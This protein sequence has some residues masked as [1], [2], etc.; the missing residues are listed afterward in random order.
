M[1]NY[2]ARRRST[3]F[4]SYKDSW[5]VLHKDWIL[6]DYQLGILRWEEISALY[7]RRR[8]GYFGVSDWEMVLKGTDKMI[9]DKLQYLL[10]DVRRIESSYEHLVWRR[11]EKKKEAELAEYCGFDPDGK[12]W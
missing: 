1:A 2:W 10:K 11:E 7:I 9:C 3:G 5:R 4:G 12:L 8:K 6:G